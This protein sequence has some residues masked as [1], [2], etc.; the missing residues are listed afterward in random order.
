MDTT[1]RSTEISTEI[2]E[3]FREWVRKIYEIEDD[4]LNRIDPET[5]EHYQPRYAAEEPAMPSPKMAKRL[6]ELYRYLDPRACDVLTMIINGELL[7]KDQ[8]Y[9]FG[10]FENMGI[11]R[12]RFSLTA[13]MF[14][15]DERKTKRKNRAEIM[16]A[17]GNKEI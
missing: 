9:G 11:M 5:G 6:E 14:V 17:F 2:C 1:L 15:S 7:Y 12:W 13:D 10:L 16:R 8:I 3:L 4:R